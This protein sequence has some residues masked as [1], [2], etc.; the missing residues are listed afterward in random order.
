MKSLFNKLH[1]IAPDMTLPMMSIY[2]G[3]QTE[4]LKK[5]KSDPKNIDKR[6]QGYKK[7]NKL[8]KTLIKIKKANLPKSKDLIL[9]MMK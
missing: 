3:V 6:T 1:K 5:M 9:E 4:T 8:M 2:T 7:I